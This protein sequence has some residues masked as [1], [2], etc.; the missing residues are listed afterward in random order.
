M[1]A[2]IYNW[3][4]ERFDTRHLKDAISRLRLH[5]YPF[6]RSWFNGRTGSYLESFLNP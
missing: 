3:F 2:E 1:L 5:R 4:A 6:F